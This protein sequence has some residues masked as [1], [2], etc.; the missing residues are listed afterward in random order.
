MG[1]LEKLTKKQQIL[2]EILWNSDSPMTSMDISRYVDGWSTTSLS[3]MINA[4]IERGFIRISNTE[5]INGHAA[6]LLVAACSKEEYAAKLVS[7]LNIKKDSFPR[8]VTALMHEFSSEE[9]YEDFVSDMESFL[10]E[11][12]EKIHKK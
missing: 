8:V 12:K 2:M 3:N 6:R 7:S 10:A 1:Y 4:L 5:V 9:G 11:Y